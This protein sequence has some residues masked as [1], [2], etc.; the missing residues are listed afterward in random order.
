MA[1]TVPERLGGAATVTPGERKVFAALRDHLPEDYLVYYAIR[2]KD[3]H[4]DF[5]VIGPD[6]GIVVLEVKDWRLRT[7]AATSADGVL[8]KT[9]DG[10]HLA[11]HPL[12]QA[13]DYILR[14]VDLLKQRPSLRAG[15]RLSCGWGY[16]AIL[17][18]LKTA[19]IQTPSLLGPTLEEALGV[20]LIL[21]ADDL[22]ADRLLPRLRALLPPWA[23][24]LPALTPGQVDEIRATL[25]PEIRVGWGRSDADVLEVMDREQERLA[26]SLGDGHRL[27]R[28]VAGSGK[29]VTLICRARHLRERHPSWRILV[30]CF[31]RVLAD[32]LRQT[33]G[34]DD[35]LDVRTFH[36]WCTRELRRAG[37]TMPPPPE[38]GQP[39]HEYWEGVPQLLLQ[40]YA[41]GRA[42][43]GTYQAILVDEGQDFADD[44]YRLI[45]G[46][47]DAE[48]NS[49]FIALDSS[50]NIYRRKVSWREI[51][52]QAAGRS[53][54][55]RV[56]YRNT[57]P[58]LAAAY[59]LISELD[60]SAAVVREAE[61]EYVVPDRAVRNG[62]PPEI[63]RHPSYHAS[64]QYVLEWIRT[65]LARG[66]AAE[67]MLVLG[68]GRLD[69]E[70]L[71]AWL[72]TVGVQAS[73]VATNA[74]PG[75]VRLSTI[76]SAKGLD[77]AHVLVIGGHELEQR[78]EEEGRRLLYI[79][80][81]RT[82]EEL[83]VCYHGD[84][85]LMA[86]LE[87]A[88]AAALS[89]DDA[90]RTHQAPQDR[91]GC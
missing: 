75:S 57:R 9:D 62:P 40:A 56:N 29:T 46:A 11:R 64:R 16:G 37:I 80:M 47:L 5:I 86:E 1:F 48:S 4:P 23:E 24:R 35:H 79:A 38:R 25:Y 53:R 81:T 6:L 68:L 33:I 49:L 82:R 28:G 26:R 70:K 54:V 42:V 66:I 85:R 31:N 36:A 30:L 59:R 27:L 21:T 89:R 71:R 8:I 77:A 67:S 58:I 84:S 69:T 52:V 51:G 13:R 61:N 12:H 65:R 74:P 63:H 50:Q 7:I 18:S 2:V 32:F 20:G 73:V 22:V 60:S 34:A 15:D 19:D 45:L 10:E 14:T 78:D 55:L 91:C 43:T 88:V 83:C 44:W 72:S 39:W 76:H 41:E 17:P 3:R 87:A 90:S